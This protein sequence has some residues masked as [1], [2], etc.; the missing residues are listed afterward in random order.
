MEGRYDCLK[1][2]IIELVVFFKGWNLNFIYKTLQDMKFHMGIRN[3]LRGEAPS[4]L[5]SLELFKY[6]FTEK[7]LQ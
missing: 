2:V 6:N 7:L 3:P 5:H 1:S 4:S